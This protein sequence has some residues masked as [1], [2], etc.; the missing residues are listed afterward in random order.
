M[1]VA[2]MCAV[3]L[4]WLVLMLVVTVAAIR[5]WA[6][7]RS[8]AR[9]PL[10]AGVCEDLRCGLQNAESA[11]YCARCGLKLPRP[12]PRGHPHQDGLVS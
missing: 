7:S 3:T 2:M 5:H 8:L 9:A 6:G 12:A 1:R 10:G 11:Q 4:I